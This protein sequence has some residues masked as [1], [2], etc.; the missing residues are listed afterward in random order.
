M[1]IAFLDDR[2]S[3][4][5][6]L[7]VTDRKPGKSARLFEESAVC[8]A[9]AEARGILISRKESHEENAIELVQ[10]ILEALEIVPADRQVR[11]VEEFALEMLKR[12]I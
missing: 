11:Q 9:L 1:K 4:I 2:G 12:N 5:H 3:E 6:S 10:K 7:I 8:G